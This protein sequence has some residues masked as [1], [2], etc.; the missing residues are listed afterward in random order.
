[1]KRIKALYEYLLDKHLSKKTGKTKTEREYDAWRQTVINENGR[2][3]EE[4][5]FG[6]KYILAVDKD[7]VMT[8][9]DP[10]AGDVSCAH[11]NSFFYPSRELGKNVEWAW[12][13][14]STHMI[15]RNFEYTTRRNLS[16]VV[17]TNSEEDAL[18]LALHYG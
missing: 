17:A 4:Y 1:M 3:L 12:I 11:F 16:L 6:L 8:D 13:D 7:K 18:I 15:G 14:N 2:T 5:F 9:F 10:F